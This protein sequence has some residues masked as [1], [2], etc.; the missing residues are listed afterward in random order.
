MFSNKSKK[1]QNKKV[2]ERNVLAK[3]T[4]IVGDIKSD[5]DFRI[6][7]TL[8]GTLVTKGRVI[9]G[10]DG[11]VKGKVECTN[12]DIEGKY[13]GNLLVL[14]TLTI[15]TKANISGEVII[16]KLSVEPG[17]TFNA[18]CTMKGAVKELNSSNDKKNRS[19]KTA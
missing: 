3:N 11:F 2:M 4:K 17:A 16:G 19:E 10:A 12:A 18:T 7:G 8:E 13:S 9:I 1:P 6:D 14:N 5:G 15:K